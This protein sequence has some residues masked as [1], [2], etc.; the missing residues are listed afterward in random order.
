MKHVGIVSALVLVVAAI[1]GPAAT[2]ATSATPAAPTAK[3]KCVSVKT[4]F[5]RYAASG[6]CK[7]GERKDPKPCARGGSCVVGDTGPGGGKVFYSARTKQPWGRYLE[8]AP[9]TWF[10]SDGDPNLM[11]CSNVTDSL[12]G[13]QATALGAGKANT[14]AMLGACTTDAAVAATS[15]RGGGKS[16]W[17]LPSR[18]ELRQ[19][20]LHKARVGEFILH[21]YW[22]SSE[23]SAHEAWIQDFYAD[24]TPAPSDKS[25]ASY[26]RPIRAF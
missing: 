20:F 25:Y 26:V 2:A 12:P 6:A 11:W 9:R 14:A 18:D 21:G 17:Y 13:T 10:S 16:D 19:L 23:Y 22:S 1:G 15:Y 8:A 4:G 7:R 3:V 24:Y 5:A